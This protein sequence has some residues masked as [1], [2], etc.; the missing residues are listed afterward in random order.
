MAHKCLLQELLKEEQEPFILNKYISDR[1]RITQ[2]KATTTIVNKKQ[3]RNTNNL[4]NNVNSCFS[5][6]SSIATP[7]KSPLFLPSPKNSNNKPIFLHIPSRTAALLL[8]AALRIHKHKNT[9]H[10]HRFSLFGSFFRRLRHNHNHRKHKLKAAH[11]EENVS[12]D[13]GFR[14]SYSVWSESN[15]DKSLDM[16]T[17]STSTT[18]NEPFCESPFRFVLQST[19]DL[20]SSPTQDKESVVVVEE[21]E[22]EDKEQCSPV[23][24]LDP[25]FEDDDEAHGNDDDEEH[26]FDLECSYATMQRAKQQLL[27]KLRRFE[28]LAGLDPVELEKLMVDQEEEEEDD[29]CVYEEESD[30]E[31]LWCKGDGLREQVFESLFES[32]SSRLEIIPEGLKRLVCDVIAEEEREFECLEEDYENRE[33]VVRKV[34][35]RM[36]LWK[37]VESNTIDMMI[38]E[39]FS[40][41]ENNGWKQ[42]NVDQLRDMAGELELAIFGF[43]VE[44]F[45]EELE[46]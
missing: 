46:F 40:R 15:Q 20:P 3:Q 37:Q 39:D 28:K 8:E 42:K 34:C 1:K 19:P 44:E 22:E 2:I 31:S 12:S 18:T 36:E 6:S 35:E 16:E 21:E 27:Y 30:E 14:S 17:S 45:S 41:E 11:H 13:M 25:P 5:S 32:S 33:M 9:T 10:A 26:G 23:S 24:V 38:Q 43:L 7:T 29:G 4:C